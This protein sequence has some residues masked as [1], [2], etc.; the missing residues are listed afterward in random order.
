MRE[1]IEAFMVLSASSPE[2]SLTLRPK[3]FIHML[4]HIAERPWS[5][6]SAQ[7]SVARMEE[8]TYARKQL[9]QP[10]G[11]NLP[12]DLYFKRKDYMPCCML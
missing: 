4:C 9:P 5:A 12:K 10:K 11:R 3:C 1:K 8:K 2:L 6:Y 7:R